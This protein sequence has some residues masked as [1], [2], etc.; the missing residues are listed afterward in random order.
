MWDIF[1]RED[2][3]RLREWLAA[4]GHSFHHRGK[5]VDMEDVGDVIFDQV[6]RD[7]ERTTM[8]AVL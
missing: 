6:G 1:K 4:N 3:P 5:P 2:V 7:W 8:M